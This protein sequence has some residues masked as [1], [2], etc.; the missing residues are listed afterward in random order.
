MG[1][2]EILSKQSEVMLNSW[3]KSKR[4][5]RTL[6]AATIVFFLILHS[7]LCCSHVSGKF[8][9]CLYSEG[10]F[11]H[12]IRE[13]DCFKNHP[14]SS[15]Y[16][17]TVSS[18]ISI[19]IYIH[20]HTKTCHIMTKWRENWLGCNQTQRHDNSKQQSSEQLVEATATEA[21]DVV[22]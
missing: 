8:R 20:A 6:T 21:I 4:T 12:V 22:S 10:L 1:T 19:Y 18:S 11:Y 16:I 2:A 5:E 3:K 15:I 17:N 13:T 14:P 7:H 9:Y